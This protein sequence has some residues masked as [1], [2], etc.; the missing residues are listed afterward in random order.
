[1][2]GPLRADTPVCCDLGSASIAPATVVLTEKQKKASRYKMIKVLNKLKIPFRFWKVATSNIVAE[3]VVEE[4][5]AGRY[6]W[7]VIEKITFVT[8]LNVLRSVLV[9]TDDC[10]EIQPMK[11]VKTAQ[12][13]Y[14]QVYIVKTFNLY[15]H[16]M[17]GWVVK[18]PGHGTR[19]P[20]DCGG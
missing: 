2:A 3:P 8:I 5:Y 17:E 7:D 11:V 1:M 9:K 18:T 20:L 10:Y 13:S 12:G 6:Q 4:N 19:R 16:E 15:S 14:H